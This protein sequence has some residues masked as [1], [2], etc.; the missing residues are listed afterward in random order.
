MDLNAQ[1]RRFTQGTIFYLLLSVFLAGVAGYY[2]WDKYQE[3]NASKELLA[4]N[5]ELKIELKRK[6]IESEGVYKAA[7]EDTSGMY[8]KNITALKDI[9]PKDEAM[10]SLTRTLDKFFLENNYSAEPFILENI[11]F[12][13]SASEEGSA[14]NILPLSITAT[15][16]RRNINKFLVFVEQSGSLASQ[17]RLLTID[18]I[19]LSFEYDKETKKEMIKMTA[20]L[21]AYFQKN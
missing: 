5:E 1:S 10:T 18:N 11:S 19:N 16:T 15:G 14:Y 13:E 17:V 20:Q 9:F 21:S 3:L 7:Q 6:N 4:R 12:S 2:S 8:E